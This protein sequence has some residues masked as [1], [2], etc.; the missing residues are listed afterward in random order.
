MFQY[1]ASVAEIC[2]LLKNIPLTHQLPFK[3]IQLVLN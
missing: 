3:L 1:T 2:N